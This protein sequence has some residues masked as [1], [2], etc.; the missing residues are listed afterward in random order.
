M[1]NLELIFKPTREQESIN[2]YSQTAEDLKLVCE[3]SSE[4]KIIISYCTFR[5][6]SFVISNLTSIYIEDS[7]IPE[8]N[9]FSLPKLKK[10]TVSQCKFSSGPRSEVVFQN[11]DFPEIQEIILNDCGLQRFSLSSSS[12]KKLDLSSN[13]LKSFLCDYPKLKLLNL[14]SNCLETFEVTPE[15]TNSLIKLNLSCN[16]SGSSVLSFKGSYPNLA[17][18]YLNG[19]LSDIDAYMPKIDE[20]NLD[21]TG[22]TFVPVFSQTLQVLSANKNRITKFAD[23]KFPN[24]KTL[25]LESNTLSELQADFP[26]LKTLRFKNNPLKII[27]LNLPSLESF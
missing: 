21:E 8:F 5:T 7:S 27:N 1:S 23:Y 10:L 4:V 14:K 22:I 20:V 26:N 17:K 18:L 15:G 12:L 13:L 3:A 6:L 16:K 11:N 9:G 24:L 2:L 19:T 25:S